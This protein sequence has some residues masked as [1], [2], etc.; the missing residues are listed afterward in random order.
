MKI[1]DQLKQAIDDDDA[2]SV[3]AIFNEHKDALLNHYCVFSFYY[4]SF[5]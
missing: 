4:S 1:E 3:V 2:Q 5:F